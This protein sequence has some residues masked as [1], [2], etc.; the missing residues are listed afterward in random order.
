MTGQ[1]MFS[2]GIGIMKYELA[3]EIARKLKIRPG[4]PVPSAFQ[5]RFG[6]AKGLLTV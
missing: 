6:G 2:D 5:I 4:K 3:I 1:Y